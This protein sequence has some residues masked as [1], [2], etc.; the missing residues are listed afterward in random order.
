MIKCELCNKNF[1][2][3]FSLSIHLTHQK[4][5]CKT[6]VKEYYNKYL[7]K[8]N[9]GICKFCNKE[10]SFASLVKGYP[11]DI[12]VHCRNLKP[13]SKKIRKENKLKKTNEKKIKNGYY[14]LPEF[15]E[16]C[17]KENKNIRFKGRS[18]LSKHISLMHNINIK[19]YYDLYFK[20]EGEGICPITG[21]NT[22]F[23]NLVCGYFKY[24][25]KGTNSADE[26][27]K[28]KKKQTLIKNFNVTNPIYVNQEK[29][30]NSFKNTFEEKRNLNEIKLQSISILRKLSINKNDK[31]Q[32]QI[33]GW[34]K[35]KLKIYNHI[36]IHNITVKEYYDTYF[37]KEGE[38]ICPV[39]KNNT[40][41]ICLEK[42][43]Y[44]YANTFQQKSIEVI[45]TIRKK[46]QKFYKPRIIENIKKFNVE[47]INEEEYHNPN[48]V[49]KLKC[50][51]CG[52]IYENKCYNIQLGYG[53]CQRCYP[54]NLPISKGE[55]ELY[56]AIKSILPNEEILSSYTDLIKS[57]KNRKLEL[58][59][60]IPSKKIAI[61]YNGLYWHSELSLDNPVTYHIYKTLECSKKD[62]RLIHI[63]EDEWKYKNEIVLNS[64]KS[65]LNCDKRKVIYARKCYIKEIDTINKGIYLDKFHIQGKD[66][67]II[68]LGAFN[69]NNEI[70]AIMTF[71]NGSISRGGNPH[72][73]NIYE[74]SRFCTCEYRVP[75]IASK[76]LAYFKRN[77]EWSE[78]YSYA[79]LRWSQGNLYNKLGFELIDQTS[80][81]YW[82]VC[83]DKRVHRFNLRKRPDEPKDTPEWVLRSLEGYYKIYDCGKLKFALIN[84]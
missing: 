13:E 67:S 38:G 58:D 73:K 53:K 81:D 47:I 62:V 37:K 35:E 20:K 23:I 83:Q 32:C 57:E 7:R 55:S 64:I 40:N 70:V 8:E 12:C 43:Y 6:N 11:K 28:D 24:K 75:G 44:K 39:S 79:D 80:P 26:K 54:R 52:N 46:L 31:N 29:R 21:D 17:K 69:N 78:I 5:T 15:C 41:F 77:Y 71:S 82:Y 33:C 25:D 59:I 9:E 42:G 76:M 16:I 45:E 56:N 18:G 74:L 60:Y 36:K 27:I 3:L 66:S 50:L 65:I 63:F 68:K 19:D 34:K 2:T 84:N 10:T 72:N 14:N 1:K 51:K 61:E 22:N 49:I 4:S 30:I 48:S